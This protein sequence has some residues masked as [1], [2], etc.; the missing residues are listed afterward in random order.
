MRKAIC[1]NAHAAHL[2]RGHL[3]LLRDVVDEN[4]LEAV[5]RG[6]IDGDFH[7]RTDL[8]DWT[9]GTCCREEVSI[10]HDKSSYL[11]A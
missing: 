10:A 2:G 4:L 9:C 5:P 3:Q 7:A 8:P 1:V 6:V 11:R